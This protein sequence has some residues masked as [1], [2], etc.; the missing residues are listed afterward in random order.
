MEIQTTF[1]FKK[2]SFPSLSWIRK[3][4]EVQ[5]DGHSKIPKSLCELEKNW[6]YSKSNMHK[7][8]F[9]ICGWIGK[10]YVLM[11]FLIVYRENFS[12]IFRCSFIYSLIRLQLVFR[13]ILFTLLVILLS[14][15]R[16]ARNRNITL[17]YLYIYKYIHI[18]IYISYIYI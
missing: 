8:R 10:S 17:I 16:F 9:W 2:S 11:L 6:K 1:I 18:Y 14:F 13:F 4:Q 12:I 15:G 5:L 3:N 7:S